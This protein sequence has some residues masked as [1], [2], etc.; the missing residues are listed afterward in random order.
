VPTA[1]VDEVDSRRDSAA[2]VSFGMAVG[3]PDCPGCGVRQ[4]VGRKVPTVAAA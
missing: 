3:E 2:N 1:L 4:D